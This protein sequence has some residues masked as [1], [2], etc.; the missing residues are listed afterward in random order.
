[1]AITVRAN[2]ANLTWPNFTVVPNKILDP[3]DGTLQ[4]AYTA[5]DFAMPALPPRAVDG[6]L[7]FADPMTITI[8][9]N[10]RIWSGVTQ[11][12]AL[13]SHE[14]LH[15][16]VGIVTAKAFVRELSR[17]RKNTQAELVTALRAAETLHFGTRTGLLQKRYDL[18]TKHGTQA[19]Y[20]RIWKERMRVCL[21]DSDA[22]H[23][24]GFW[25]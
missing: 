1:M 4:D 11:T 7:A 25:L 8:T 21:A 15:Y 19:H 23:L 10:A 14:Q 9:P 13:L 3:A 22:T 17:L 16:D 24:G 5:F 12:A 18:D 6:K 2:P 20:Q